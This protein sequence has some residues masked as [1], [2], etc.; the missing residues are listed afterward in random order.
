MRR[1]PTCVLSNAAPPAVSDGHAVDRFVEIGSFT[2]VI[3]GTALTCMAE[4]GMLALDDP[5]ERWLPA[6]PGT[7][8]TLLDLARHTSGL[9]RLPPRIA[10]RD[11][12]AK[13][14]RRTVHQLLSRLDTI[15][16]CPP[17]QREEYSNLGYAVLGEALTAAAGT[18]YEELV[19]KYVLRPLDITEVTATPDP[20]TYLLARSRLGRA[21][22]PWTMHGAI[23][24]AGGLWATP[25][26]GCRPGRTTPHRTQVGR[27]RAVLAD[28][29]LPALAQWRHARR[30][31]VRRRNR[32]RPL[33]HDP[34]P[35]RST[36]G[37]GPSRH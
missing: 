14:D 36:R 27:S 13:F 4:A 5:L 28:G 18:T 19:T 30:L 22:Q 33:G 6:T 12:Y 7:G 29:R 34:P 23:L 11:P 25:P 35:W 8:I 31:A 3:T 17:G 10:R 2:K 1:I 32:R 15:A 21:R 16:T 26:R 37:N 24:P 20:G 9:P